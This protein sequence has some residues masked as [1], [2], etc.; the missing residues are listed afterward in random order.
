MPATIDP[1]QSESFASARKRALAKE[2]LKRKASR[3]TR[4]R[5]EHLE[6]RA[7]PAVVVDLGAESVSEVMQAAQMSAFFQQSALYTDGQ[8]TGDPT[9]T[10]S[11]ARDDRASQPAPASQMIARTNTSNQDEV[12][13]VHSS[14]VTNDR[15]GAGSG[16]AWGS[17]KPSQT[18][19]AWPAQV[20]APYVDMGAWPTFDLVHAAHAA[21]IKYFNLAFV[22]ADSLDQAS[23]DGHD[24]NRIGSSF[25]RALRRQ[26]SE[27]RA[28]GGDVA[29]SF[30][31]PRQLELAQVITDVGG[32]AR[33]YRGVIDAYQLRRIDF[34]LE[35]SALDDP[36]SIE[37]R[38]RA[39]AIVQREL[40]DEDRSLEISFTL[41]AEAAGLT[42]GGLYAVRAAVDHGVELAAVNIKP[43][44]GTN[45]RSPAVAGRMGVYS[46][47][48]AISVF[49]QL[50][51]NLPGAPSP[52]Q[53]WSKIG[54]TPRI[55]RGESAGESFA[56]R[57]AQAVYDF[58][59]QQGLGMIG[60]WSINRDQYDS[61]MSAP[62]SDLT[63]GVEQSAFDFSEIFRALTTS[64]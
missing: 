51:N 53:I 35:G 16:R 52:K 26:V 25:D 21:G 22:S 29:V 61:A 39:L 48:A 36:A 6:L 54:I 30:G 15:L 58:A 42:E 3:R 9:V 45:L 4:L 41:P 11:A 1:A 44:L 56:P 20:F 28:M 19:R 10:W 17:V 2:I 46:I 12:R 8:P 7:V 43:T 38:S 13:D 40:A 64:E 63:S 60:I 34:D 23:W 27:L 24:Q 50:E 37:R 33:A 18:L 57:D 59:R 32:L 62:P 5:F 14:V 55:G 47:E 31:G 49:Y